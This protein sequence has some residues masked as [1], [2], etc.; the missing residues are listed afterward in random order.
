[1]KVLFSLA[2]VLAIAASCLACKNCY[3]PRLGAADMSI[4]NYTKMYRHANDPCKEADGGQCG[5]G[6]CGMEM[7]KDK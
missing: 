4:F 5:G 2:A 6:C 3:S 1:M 7:K